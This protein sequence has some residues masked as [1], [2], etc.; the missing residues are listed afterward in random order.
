MADDVAL[1]EAFRQGQISVYKSV[2]PILNEMISDERLTV[3]KEGI[4]FVKMVLE[5]ADPSRK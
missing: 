1:K 2:L 5:E 4:V 3:N